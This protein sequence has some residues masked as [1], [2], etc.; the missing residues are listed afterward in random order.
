M[1]KFEQ[2]S[3]LYKKLC[4]FQKKSTWYRSPIGF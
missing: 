3:A 2:K 1:S 4:F